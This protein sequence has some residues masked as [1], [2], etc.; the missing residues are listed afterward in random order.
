MQ[1]TIRTRVLTVR[2]FMSIFLQ[3]LVSLLGVTGVDA[4]FLSP[5]SRHKSFLDRNCNQGR[6]FWS[7]RLVLHSMGSPYNDNDDYRSEIRQLREKATNARLLRT[8]FNSGGGRVTKR[9]EANLMELD[10]VGRGLIGQPPNATKCLFLTTSTAQQI[11][12][13]TEDGSEWT[14]SVLAL[15]LPL[16]ASNYDAQ[17]KL[18]SFAYVAKPI[19]K[20]LC[21]TLNPILVNRDGSFFDNLPWDTWTVDPQMRNRDAAGNSIEKKFHLGKRDAYNR[22]MGKDWKGRSLSSVTWH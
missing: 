12:E 16:S 13:R 3:G 5:P 11:L 8:L 6:S 4:A 1:A 20:S 9:S 22:F 18:L 2:F 14:R 7:S 10:L 21:L 19:S 15:A 17:L